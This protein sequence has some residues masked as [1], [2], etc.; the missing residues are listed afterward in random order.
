MDKHQLLIPLFD[1]I[2]LVRASGRSGTDGGFANREFDIQ[3][4]REGDPQ[5]GP[6]DTQITNYED[7]IFTVR[8][9][10]DQPF[11]GELVIPTL[12]NLSKVVFDAIETFELALGIGIT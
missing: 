1:T 2:R 8:F 7:A 5:N 4:L 6:P 9:V 11:E 10:K 12:H 3:W